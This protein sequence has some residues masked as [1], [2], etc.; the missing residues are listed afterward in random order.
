MIA[1]VLACGGLARDSLFRVAQ[2]PLPGGGTHIL[3]AATCGGGVEAN[4]AVSLARLG[5]RVGLIS[6]V[7]ADAPG[8][9]LLAELQAEGVEVSGVR[10]DPG[11]ETDYCLI[12]VDAHGERV[13][14]CRPGAL[15][16]LRLEAADLHRLRS[17]R[18]VCFSGYLPRELQLELALGLEGPL[19]A[20]DLPD[21][22]SDLRARGLQP[23]DLQRIVGRLA[24]LVMNERGLEGLGGWGRVVELARAQPTLRL[25]VTLGS[26]GSRLH[27]RGR[28]AQIPALGAGVVDS[29]GAGDAYHAG[30]VDAWLLR[31][32]EMEAA[33]LWAAAVA[34]LSCRALGA[35]AG[36]PN[37]AEVQ[38]LLE[39][40]P[41]RSP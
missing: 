25:A 13:M 38:A 2:L 3:E 39:A 40:S 34:G 7:G 30:L 8:G 33:G 37:P 23:A 10:M 16:G 26:R 21:S 14:A 1:E 32:E 28:E 29:T 24:L 31:G 20:Y 12:L 5:R 11:T 22:F 35:R 41:P 36:L 9:E 19:L 18:V 6:R 17:T 15:R 4:L 27:H